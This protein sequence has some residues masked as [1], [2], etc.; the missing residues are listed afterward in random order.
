MAVKWQP[1]ANPSDVVGTGHRW[2]EPVSQEGEHK[3][4]DL[5]ITRG[6][7]ALSPVDGTVVDVNNDPEGLGIT[8]TIQDE[9]GHTHTLGHLDGAKVKQGDRVRIGQRVGDVGSTGASTG[10]HLDY[11]IQDQDGNHQDPTAL[12]GPLAQMPRADQPQA[13]AGQSESGWEPWVPDAPTT[14]Y[15]GEYPGR[16]PNWM[17]ANVGDELNVGWGTPGSFYSN[18]PDV[19][20]RFATADTPQAGMDPSAL[21]QVNVQPGQQGILRRQF[22]TRA[23]DTHEFRVPQDVTS[24][25]T[26]LFM[27]NA[28]PALMMV[29]DSLPP[30]V[31]QQVNDAPYDALRWVMEHRP[32]ALR[33]AMDQ[34]S[35]Q[36]QHLP[37]AE[38]A[39][40]AWQG[41]G[42]VARGVHGVVSG[43]AFAPWF[44]PPPEDNVGGGQ[45]RPM[46]MGKY[47][48]DIV[49]QPFGSGQGVG[50]GQYGGSSSGGMGGGGTM[51]PGGYYGQGG[52][53]ATQF[54]STGI[55]IFAPAGTPVQAPGDGQIVMGSMGLLLKLNNGPYMR[56]VHVQPNVSPGQRVHKGDP[57]AIIGDPS[58]SQSYQHADVAFSS[59][60]NNWQMNGPAGPGGMGGDMDARQ[61]LQQLGVQEQVIPG[62]TG[63]I[64]AMQR[65]VDPPGSASIDGQ[66]GAS[67]GGGMGGGMMGGMGGGGMMGGMGGGMGLPGGKGMPGGMGGMGMPGGMGGG[68]MGGMPGG[69]GGGMGMPGGMGGM[70]GGGPM[71]MMGGGGGFP[72]MGGFGGMGGGGGGRGGMGMPSFGGMAGGFGGGGFGGGG[73]GGM[74]M[75]SPFG[76]MGGGSP[77]GMMGGGFGGGGFGGGMMGDAMPMSPGM[78]RAPFGGPPSGPMPIPDM[79]AGGDVRDGCEPRHVPAVQ[80]G[81]HVGCR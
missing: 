28:L 78:Q 24:T 23:P 14:L 61:V 64:A 30:D 16:G 46:P 40:A 4:V 55:D 41:A 67:M 3:A 42:D 37:G 6:K 58:L 59:S 66:M 75:G 25:R 68:M 47:R 17:G 38:Q 50:V 53:W 69:M 51:V 2:L 60:P 1:P 72:G 56:L 11:R 12:L 77:M 33:Q 35:Q 80:R 36:A 27:N 10:P 63:G 34:M 81:L 43:Q 48:W 8:V 22:G 21:Y 62:A 18:S 31:R 52:K 13:G 19:A 65:G 32:D 15:R 9:S 20:L 73:F 79:N 44:Q 74:G 57:I 39:Q 70:M 26:P 5:Q 7:P 76:M 45:D 49:D 29:A 54:G 71:G